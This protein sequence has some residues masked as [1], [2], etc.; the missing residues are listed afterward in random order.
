VKKY[1]QFI[2]VRPQSKDRPRFSKSGYA[3]TSK[4]T[5]DYEKL[6]AEEYKGPMI[7]ASHTVAVEL[8]FD[9]SGTF[10]SVTATE[11]PDWKCSVKGDLDNYVKSILDALNGVAW[12]DDKQVI[13][14]KVT[15]S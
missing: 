10:I 9:V 6:I 11:N 3:Y 13:S 12:Q 4:R 1:E 8:N 7:D 5:R 15:K 14:L 2:A